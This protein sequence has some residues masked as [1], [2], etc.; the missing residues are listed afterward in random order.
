MPTEPLARHEL[1][2]IISQGMG[3]TSFQYEVWV[4]IPCID[5]PYKL[6]P[7][8]VEKI[9]TE[10]AKER[11]KDPVYVPRLEEVR[12][13]S[14]INVVAALIPNRLVPNIQRFTS[15]DPALKP[16][17]EEVLRALDELERGHWVR[18]VSVEEVDERKRIGRWRGDFNPELTYWVRC[19]SCLR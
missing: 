18:K 19:E 15:E 12:L 4:A 3:L 5:N 17:E 13:A 14:K 16:S 2:E 10:I 11:S 1:V 7:F 6:D 9:A 8:T